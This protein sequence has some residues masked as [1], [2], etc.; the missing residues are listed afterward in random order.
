M[1]MEPPKLRRNALPKFAKRQ[2]CVRCTVLT[3]N[4][5]PPPRRRPLT[6]DESFGIRRFLGDT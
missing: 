1:G 6:S 2:T 4:H 5:D 3:A